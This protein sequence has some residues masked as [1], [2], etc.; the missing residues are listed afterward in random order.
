MKRDEIAT[1]VFCALIARDPLPNW[2]Y[3]EIKHRIE[4]M[5]DLAVLMGVA[6]EIRLATDVQTIEKR[7]GTK[8]DHA[9]DQFTPGPIAREA[10]RKAAETGKNEA[11]ERRRLAGLPQSLFD[12]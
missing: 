4:E 7:F 9:K 10:E 12:E 1:H 3:L 2:R 8:W 6:L 5:A 11:I